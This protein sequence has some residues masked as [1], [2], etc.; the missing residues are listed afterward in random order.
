M[1]SLQKTD[2]VTAFPMPV[3]NP[4]GI[5]PTEYKVLIR[6]IEVEEKTKGGII[7]PGETKDKEQFAQQEGILVAVSPVAFNFEAFPDGTKPKPGDRVLY[8]K[9]A[10]FTRKGKDGVDY[11]VVNDKDVAAILI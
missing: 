1:P 7:L 4:S 11:K 8:A 5:Q 9:Y 3:T 10:G 6:P 2:T